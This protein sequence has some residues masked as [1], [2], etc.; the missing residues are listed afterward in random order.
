MNRPGPTFSIRKTAGFFGIILLV[1]AILSLL[2]WLPSIIQKHK[3]K[4]YDTVEAA[5]KELN[6]VRIYLPTYLP[7]H[8]GLAWPPAEIYAQDRPF[9]AVIMHFDFKDGKGTGLVIHEVDARASFPLE[10]RMKI[11][12]LREERSIS[13][14]D[15]SAHLALAECEG[16]PCSRLSWN[17]SGTVLTL[18]GKCP[19]QELIKIAA[20]ML[21]DPR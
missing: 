2:N 10:P 11:R 18:I 6:A 5:K 16:S 20:S 8:I 4:K 14:K 12:R 9:N 7:E 13:V 19:A 21:S 15:R 1:L 17:E 3:L